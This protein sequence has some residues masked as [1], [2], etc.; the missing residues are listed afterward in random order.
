MHILMMFLHNLPVLC[1]F[2]LTCLLFFRYT[3]PGVMQMLIPF[4]ELKRHDFML[5]DINAMVQTPRSAQWQMQNRSKTSLLYI[6][7]G[8]C[9]FTSP[10]G[11][12]SAEEGALLYLPKGSSHSVT[13]TGGSLE[14]CT[15]NFELSINGEMVLFSRYPLKLTDHASSDCQEAVWNLAEN[16]YSEDNTVAKSCMLCTIFLSLQHTQLNQRSIQLSPA[17]RCMREQIMQNPVKGRFC[18][19]ELAALCNL[20]TAQF[21][22]L[23]RMEYG[24]TPLE[25]HNNLLLHKAVL[26]LET[27]Q[28]AVAEIASMMGFDSPAYF[29]RFF[30]K[31][32]GI[33]PSKLLLK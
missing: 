29:S 4:E 15:V 17:I 1:G 5:S 18:A 8:S 9:C 23:F 7:G 14:Y 31:H 27:Q 26:L 28:Y 6:S 33:P 11:V 21:Y 2:P 13:V 10:E 30:K 24:I 32:K 20:S 12:F 25:Y 19:A 3:I 22:H 16:Y